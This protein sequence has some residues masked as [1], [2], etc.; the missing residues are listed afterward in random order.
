[1]LLADAAYPAVMLSPT[2]A[3]C[4]GIRGCAR[5]S[6]GDSAISAKTS[7]AGANASLKDKGVEARNAPFMSRQGGFD[8]RARV[9]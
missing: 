9:A 5:V 6:A 7:A 1:M 4:V 8:Q 3:T 2:Q